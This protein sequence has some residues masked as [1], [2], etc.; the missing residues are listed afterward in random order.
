MAFRAYLREYFCVN[1]VSG[2][3]CFGEDVNVVRCAYA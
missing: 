1:N 3:V 2:L